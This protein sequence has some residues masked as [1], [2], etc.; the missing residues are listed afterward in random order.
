MFFGGFSIPLTKIRK[1]MNL[2]EKRT[3]YHYQ[4]TQN[5]EPFTKTLRIPFISFY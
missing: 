2:M 4:L 5:N 1:T 3:F